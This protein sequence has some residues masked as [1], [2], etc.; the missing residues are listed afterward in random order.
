[1]TNNLDPRVTII[2]NSQGNIMQNNQFLSLPPEKQQQARGLVGDIMSGQ[3]NMINTALDHSNL[4]NGNVIK[5]PFM[6]INVTYSYL[7][8]RDEQRALNPHHDQTYIDEASAALNTMSQTYISTEL[9]DGAALALLALDLPLSVAVTGAITVGYAS[10]KFYDWFLKDDVITIVDY[11]Y[12]NPFSPSDS[13][14]IT[15]N[16]LNYTPATGTQIDYKQT[17]IDLLTGVNSLSRYN[18]TPI[19]GNNLNISTISINNP[20]GNDISYNIQSGDSNAAMQNSGMLSS[21]H[22]YLDKY[23]HIL[24]ESDVILTVTDSSGKP[25]S[26]IREDVM[27]R[28]SNGNFASVSDIANAAAA[29]ERHFS[30]FV[31]NAVNQINK[32]LL[33][34]YDDPLLMAQVEGEFLS[35]IIA[36]DSIEDIATDVAIRV[37][38]TVVVN[39][40]FSGS[41]SAVSGFKAGLISFGTSVAIRAA[42]GDNLHS[43]DYANA[44]AI[45][46][47]S[48]VAGKIDFIHGAFINS[49]AASSNAIVDFSTNLSNSANA[50]IAAA[51][52]SATVAIINDPHMNR[53]EYE[54]TAKQAAVAATIA[55][56]VALIVGSYFPP[57]A[58]IGYVVGAVIGAVIAKLGGVAIYNLV[59]NIHSAGEDIYDTF[60]DMFIH[61]ELFSASGVEENLRQLAGAVD[62]LV[63]AV[64]IDWFKDMTRGI[65]DSIFGIDSEREYLAG[66]YP[67]SYAFIQTIAK[68]DG[69]G[70]KIIG[71]ER[72]GVVAIASQGGD[73]DIYGTDGNDIL[74]GKDGINQIFGGNGDDHIEGRDNDDVLIGDDGD[75]EILGGNGNDYIAG[76]NND[77]LIYGED[78]DDQILAGAGNDYI[79]GGSGDDK[80]EANDGNDIIYAG[81]GYDIIVAGSGNDYIEANDGNDSILGEDGD[82]I[83]VAG[84]GNDIVDGGNGNDIISGNDGNDNLKGGNGNDQ[85]FGGSGVD[86]ISGDAGDDMI[87]GGSDGDLIAAGL[88]D[89]IIFGNDGDDSLYG[90]MGND[91]LIGGNGDDILDS[92]IGDDI[93]YGG[94]GNDTLTAGKGNDTYLF[95]RGDGSDVIAINDADIAD[96]DQILAGSDTIRLGDISSDQIISGQVILSKSNND[97]IIQFKDNHGNLTNDQI[98]IKNQFD[99]SNNSTS[100]IDRI[101]F[102]DNKKIELNGTNGISVNSDNSINYQ[103]IAYNNID[104]AIQSELAQ[105]YQ[106]L[107]S[108]D[109]TSMIN[110]NSSFYN[111]NYAT[112]SN[113]SQIDH[114]QFNQIEWRAIQKTTGG[115]CGFYKKNYAVWEKYYE[116]TLNGN[117]SNDRAVGNWWNETINGLLGNDDLSGNGGDDIIYG[118]DGN[119]RISGGRGNDHLYGGSGTDL[120]YGGSDNDLVDGGDDND[121]LIGNNGHDIMFGGNDDDRLEGNGGNDIINGNDGNDLI[122]GREGSDNI[123]GGNGDDYLS[124]GVGDDI[125]NGDEGNDVIFGDLGNDR[126]FG[127]DGIDYIYAGQGIDLINGEDG[128]DTIYAGDGDDQILGGNGNDHINGNAG[129]DDIKGEDGDDILYG[130]EGGDVINGGDGNDQIF[131]GVGNDILID[132]SGSDILD[133]GIGNDILI[134]TKETATSNSVDTI[135]N[136]NPNED[137]IILRVDYRSPVN[138]YTVQRMMSQNGNNVEVNFDNGQKIIINNIQI[139]DITHSNFDIALSNG[140]ENHNLFGTN[141]D[142]I[143]FGDDY[144][145]NIFGG[146]GNDEL[147]GNGGSDALYGQN[148]DDVLRYQEDGKYMSEAGIV[149][150]DHYVTGP[151]GFDS[152]NLDNQENLTLYTQGSDRDGIRIWIRGSEIPRMAF[153]NYG[154]RYGDWPRFNNYFHEMNDN[155]RPYY[156]DQDIAFKYYDS[157]QNSYSVISYSNIWGPGHQ[158]HLNNH[159]NHAIKH[160]FTK[161]F[162]NGEQIVIDG[163]NQTLDSFDGGDGKDI[164]IM[165]EGNDIIALE[166]AN[167]TKPAEGARVKNISTI[168]AGSGDDIINFTSPH[169]TYLDI[170][171]YGGD[172]NDKIWSSIG[173]DNLFGQD[174]NDQIYGGAGNDIIDGGI[175]DDDLNGGE[176]NDIL[177]GGIGDNTLTGGAG[178]DMFDFDNFGNNSQMNLIT[179]FTQ[180]QDLIKLS[181]SEYD[182]ISYGQGSAEEHGL[183]YYFDQDNNTIIDDPNSD[184]MIKI[185]GHIEL[186][187][188]DFLFG[189]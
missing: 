34:I 118:G 72:E 96:T 63:R 137:R 159:A 177:I 55:V 154:W 130:N 40:V 122:Y 111:N 10:S 106:D 149:P 131:G 185:A 155:S 1:M 58:P 85:I 108:I 135:N 113:A 147:W 117:N 99:V 47:T 181:T 26:L 44:A 175:G 68:P 91:Y 77:D 23:G 107:L 152:R 156:T 124:G 87:D 160:Y 45:A 15:G 70:S 115:F 5:E 103:I 83:I 148:G 16:T 37:A 31:T 4:P 22:S 139:S 179:D 90:E 163:Y 112:N 80:I 9:A 114:E 50:G 140:D 97:L 71:V 66:Q 183:E 128:D 21:H 164:M 46:A 11:F 134:L 132:G 3:S 109:P 64:T 123:T 42:Q 59:S 169:Y 48:A 35:R 98:T 65:I 14:L 62:D 67:N 27:A 138:F 167:S 100:L 39:N 86:I 168:Y 20:N 73:D 38:N 144:D 187:N 142:D 158:Y 141:E 173:N 94:K 101:E 157:E 161:N 92:F 13:F 136:F 162:Y 174:G 153:G 2:F 41:S 89:D 171:I 36:G 189:A 188:A 102:S 7:Q 178:N 180:H 125:I 143:L 151:N 74:V 30:D 49:S 121:N 110:S 8:Y 61:G 172:G 84:S 69:T 95:L 120:I 29:S 105:G 57:G 119:D 60:E 127:G 54:E 25:Y 133:G 146:D 28:L 79:E 145:N 6:V 12:S 32:P 51:I 52:V 56:T 93:F 176:G 18:Q 165:T 17:A 82:D 166:D 75:D 116:P 88:G 129:A 170:T 53:E 182:H 78:G 76:G 81:D 150:F 43:Q 24:N 33:A 126:I 186:N 184:F 104:T 19:P